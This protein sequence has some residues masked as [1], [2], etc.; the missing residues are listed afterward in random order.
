MTGLISR[1]LWVLLILKRCMSTFSELE[2]AFVQKELLF[3][4][5]L[6]GR[7]NFLSKVLVNSLYVATIWCELYSKYKISHIIFVQLLLHQNRRTSF[8]LDIK[9]PHL[10]IAPLVGYLEVGNLQGIL[11]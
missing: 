11:Y 1:R 4:G 10:Q 5:I 7:Y 3:Q 6:Y 8:G 9:I 2:T